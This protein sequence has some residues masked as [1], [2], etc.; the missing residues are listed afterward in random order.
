MNSVATSDLDINIHSNGGV[1]VGAA[2]GIGAGVGVPL[3][4]VVGILTLL[5]IRE[6]KKGLAA[7]PMS[8]VGTSGT[9]YSKPG[10]SMLS[11]EKYHQEPA[12][13]RGEGTIEMA[14]RTPERHEL[15]Q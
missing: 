9:R 10:A 12:R 2:A 15:P 11:P 6:R 8:T 5:L 14:E 3:L 7:D 13:W 4:I 1:S